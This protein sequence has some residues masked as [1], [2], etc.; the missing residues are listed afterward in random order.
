MN[1]STASA[2]NQVQNHGTSEAYPITPVTTGTPIG[3]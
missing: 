1:A 2:P 3:M